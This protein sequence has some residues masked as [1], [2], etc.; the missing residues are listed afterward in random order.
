M[1]S[2]ILKLDSEKITRL[3]LNAKNKVLNNYGFNISIKKI[4][5][6]INEII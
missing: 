2:E 1:S 3:G 5:G 6:V 4:E